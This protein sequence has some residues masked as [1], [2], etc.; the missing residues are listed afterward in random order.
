MKIGI[1]GAGSIG[2]NLGKRFST[3]GHDIRFGVRDVEKTRDIVAA[4]GDRASAGSVNEAA[5]FGDVV[6][7]AVPWRAVFEA[8]SAAG[9]L[10]NKILVDTTNPIRFE[11]GPVVD[12]STSGAEI[13]AE[14]TGARVIKAFNTLGAEHI[15]EPNVHGQKA[16]VFLCSDDPEAKRTLGTLA[17]QIGFAVVDAGPLR[18]ARFAEHLAAGWIHMAMKGGLGRNIAFKLMRA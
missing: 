6:I 3:Q 14:K 12:V 11:N 18:S 10:K 7:L 13:I 9:D 17:E 16:D 8:L 4:C 15:L 1:I 5:A 2:G